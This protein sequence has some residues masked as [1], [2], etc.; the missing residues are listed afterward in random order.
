M[1]ILLY[2]SVPIFLFPKILLDRENFEKISL[3]PYNF[4][5]TS[6]ILVK[7]YIF[8]S[9]WHSETMVSEC[10]TGKPACQISYRQDFP[11]L[12]CHENIPDAAPHDFSDLYKTPQTFIQAIIIA[13][14]QFSE[15]LHIFQKFLRFGRLQNMS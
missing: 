9:S 2:K 4:C 5:D 13:G 1:K 11:P 7:L 3:Y 8:I 14:S 12:D 15:I 10:Q 6:M